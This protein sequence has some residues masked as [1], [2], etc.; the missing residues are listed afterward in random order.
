M[1]RFR[2]VQSSAK[3]LIANMEISRDGQ[4][5]S[6][7]ACY[8]RD[9]RYIFTLSNWI[10]SS[11]GIWPIAFRG[12]KQHIS[13]ISIVICN[14]VL[15]FA[16]VPCALHIIYDQKDLIIRLKLF[17]LLGFCGTA[18][19]K[20]FVLVI[21]R[22][23]IRKCIEYVKDD[24]WQVK[25]KSDREH[26]LKYAGIGRNLFLICM[27]VTYSAVFSYHMILPFFTEHKLGNET[28]KPL[29]YPV[30]SEFIQCQ[31]SPTYE[32]VF[33][34][35]CMC[36]YIIATITVGT[37]GLAAIFAIHACGQIQVVL[38]RLEDLLDGTNFQQI[39]DVQQR[40]AAIVK[41]HIQ[42]MR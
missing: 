31:I 9:V 30:Y 38:S 40:I 41:S 13:K 24:W 5:T 20:F 26:M 8:Q 1:L 12:I 35:H 2:V 10:L 28:I 7:N 18:M 27:I 33:M 22:P 21:R 37:C 25:S 23:K 19:I 14:F 39:P 36:G 4:A 29:V 17:G 42:I 34:V 6:L 16:M 15:S 3:S 32:I 11:I